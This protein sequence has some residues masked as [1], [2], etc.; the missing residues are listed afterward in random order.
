MQVGFQAAASGAAILQYID[1]AIGVATFLMS[2]RLPVTIENI[3]SF[4]RRKKVEKPEI[5]DPEEAK[6]FV[7][8]LITIDPIILNVLNDKVK[9]A[10]ASYA[11]CLRQAISP[12][13][14]AACD[15]RAER[16]VCDTLNRL[17]DRNIGVLP[18]DYLKNQWAAF[19]CVR[20]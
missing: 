18:S 8:S 15:R 16:S 12:Q 20:V 11:D 3:R 1:T 14:N 7:A 17:M 19:G 13:E 2:E 9:D 5:F 6:D 10:I 4:F